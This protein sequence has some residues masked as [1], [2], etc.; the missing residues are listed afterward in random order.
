MAILT[1]Q[2]SEDELSTKNCRA[3]YVDVVKNKNGLTGQVAFWFH[4]PYFRH[5]ALPG[6]M[7]HDDDDVHP[8]YRANDEE[9]HDSGGGSDDKSAGAEKTETELDIEFPFK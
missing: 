8:H 1:Y 2:N 3:Q 5:E 4:A 9:V 6:G 7:D